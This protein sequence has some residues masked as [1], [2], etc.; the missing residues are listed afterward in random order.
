MSHG[1]T[2]SKTQCPSTHDERERMSKIP[3][4][5]AI[6]SIMYAM[7][8]TRP[9]V[10]CAL[11]MTSRYQ[12]DPGERHWIV[13]KNILK[14]LRRTKDNFLVYRGSEELVVSG[15]TDASFQTDKDDFRSQSGFVFCLNGGAFITELGVVP[16]ISGPIDLYCDNNGAIAQAKE[17]RSH[18]KSKHIQRR[19]HLIHE[20]I[21]RGDVKISRVSTDA[22][23][24]DLFTKPLPQPKHESHTSAIGIRFIKIY[25]TRDQRE[26][27][28][29]RYQ[30]TTTMFSRIDSNM[31]L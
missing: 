27:E 16:S 15:Y 6:G 17:P 1:I 29:K 4:A 31:A 23:V 21:D 10:A 30:Q 19:Y 22:N 3:Y 11:S 12:S 25:R 14:Y 13:V 28:V 9:D 18:Q 26:I 7:L 5:S 24:A 2:L 20:I 8:C